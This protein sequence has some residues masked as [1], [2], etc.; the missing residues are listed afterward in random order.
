MDEF[1]VIRGMIAACV[2]MEKP[3]RANDQVRAREN[4]AAGGLNSGKRRAEIIPRKSA[5]TNKRRVSLTIANN[6]KKQ[7][8]PRFSSISRLAYLQYART[9]FQ[10]KS[11]KN[12]S[13]LGAK[14][15][16]GNKGEIIKGKRP[17]AYRQ[18]GGSL[19]HSQP[20]YCP[21]KLFVIVKLTLARRLFF[22]RFFA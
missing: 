22:L 10:R 8:F 17:N 21:Q 7:S 5:I 15:F 20:P 6:L 13:F 12:P 14:R 16:C 4:C 11:S 1:E 18:L 3:P 2:P 19:T 9:Q